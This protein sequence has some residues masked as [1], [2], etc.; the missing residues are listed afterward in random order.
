MGEGGGVGVRRLRRLPL[1]FAAGG[2]GAGGC[3][4]G[5]LK[6]KN[7]RRRF[8]KS[9]KGLQAVNERRRAACR[10]ERPGE[11]VNAYG[12]E[13]GGPEQETRYDQAFLPRRRGAHEVAACG[14]TA[15]L[16]A[17]TAIRNESSN[18]CVL[19][20]NFILNFLSDTAERK[21]AGV[22]VECNSYTSALSE[23]QKCV[24]LDPLLSKTLKL[25]TFFVGWLCSCGLKPKT[26]KARPPALP[27]TSIVRQGSK[28]GM[29]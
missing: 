20:L 18:G 27:C 29:H 8:G 2:A 22:R 23:A 21:T 19:S 7:R 26:G 17:K 28:Q 5:I 1:L 14:D 15:A 10:E 3:P 11:K 12:T 13:L 16:R 24:F 6:R 25:P 4:C 9:Q